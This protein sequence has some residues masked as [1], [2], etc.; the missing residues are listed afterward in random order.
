VS[1]DTRGKEY[2]WAK[3]RVPSILLILHNEG[4]HRLRFLSALRFSTFMD[5]KN[6][7][8]TVQQC[9]GKK[10]KKLNK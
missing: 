5:S 1:I 6:L 2:F 3:V 9:D 10:K 8:P 4:G 7:I